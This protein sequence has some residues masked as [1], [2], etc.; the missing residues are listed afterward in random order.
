[1]KFSMKKMLVRHIK[2]NHTRAFQCNLCAKRFGT[3]RCLEEHKK[4]VHLKLRPFVCDL[5]H[6]GFRSKHEVNGHKKSAH[7]KDKP[8]QCSK[9]SK[10]FTTTTLLDH[11][12]ARVHELRNCETCPHCG[13]VFSRLQ[14]HLLTCSVKGS[15]ELLYSVPAVR[16]LI[17]R[18]KP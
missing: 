12:I 3:E 15:A 7:S 17:Y 18:N 6:E 5:C 9:C 4:G 10:T 1:M 13:K 8:Y 16:I 14:A 2:V 11:H